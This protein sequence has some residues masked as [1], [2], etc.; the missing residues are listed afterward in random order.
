V[1]LQDRNG[2]KIF[3]FKVGVNRGS[4]VTMPLFAFFQRKEKMQILIVGG[5]GD[6]GQ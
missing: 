2:N 3:I 5:A 6:V 1:N 4:I